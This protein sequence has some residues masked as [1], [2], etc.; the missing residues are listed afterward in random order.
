M[1]APAARAGAVVTPLSATLA[2]PIHAPIDLPPT[3]IECS[4]D[5]LAAA[6]E[7]PVDTVPAR[8]EPFGGYVAASRFDAVRGAI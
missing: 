7:P 3:A 1:T 6:V 2:A 4:I 5:R 8:V